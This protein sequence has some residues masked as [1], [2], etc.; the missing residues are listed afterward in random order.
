VDAKPHEFRFTSVVSHRAVLKRVERSDNGDVAGTDA[1]LAALQSNLASYEQEKQANQTNITNALLPAPKN[2]FEAARKERSGKKSNGPGVSQPTSPSL[3]AVGTSRLSSAPRS[4]PESAEDVKMQ[5]MKAP[6][7]HMLAMQPASTEDI[8]ERTHIPR[9]ELDNVLQK[10]GRQVDGKWQLTDRAYRELDIWKFEYPSAKERMTA[11]DNAVRAFDRMRI[12][13]E[14][15]LWQRLMSKEEREKGV[16]LSKLHFGGGQVNSLTPSYQPSPMPHA[17]AASDSRVAS[18]A[19]TPRLG[20]STTRPGSSKGD[21]MKRLLSKNPKKA[22]AAEEAKDRKRKER[23]AAA[24]D[25]EGPRPAKKQQTQKTSSNVKS[26]EFV[27]SSDDDS[28]DEPKTSPPSKAAQQT[29]KAKPKVQPTA[30]SSSSSDEPVKAKVAKKAAGGAK[31]GAADNKTTESP[32]L[33]ATKPM[34]TSKATP[35]TTNNLSAPN[36]QHKSSRSPQKQGSKPTVPSPLGAARPRVAS[37]VSDRGAVGVQRVRSNTNDS[38]RGLGITNGVKSQHVKTSG[39]E[40]NSRDKPPA[41]RFTLKSQKPLANGSATPKERLPNDTHSKVEGSL[42]RKAEH[43]IPETLKGASAVKH[44]KNNSTSSQSLNGHSNSSMSN[45]ETPRT[46]PDGLVESSSDSAG[47][48]IETIS[49]SQ[50]VA[51]A[52][53]FRDIYYPAYEKLY[54]ELQARIAKGEKVPEEDLQRLLAMHKRC[55]QFKKEMKAASQREHKD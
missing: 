3:G 38:P 17:D 4:V 24:S 49:Y 36:S 33:K 28:S 9:S 5:A 53:K 34:P 26:A 52:E 50:G 51:V 10:Y 14:D 31:S 25:R 30:A 27:H 21:V 40:S 47:S 1:A 2:R 37:D 46:S 43:Q 11:R 6:L 55:E 22:Q 41:D 7:L 39:A 45:Q 54:D 19:N 13:K 16:I 15:K 42:K 35:S 48:V 12:G 32:A 29:L 44:R 8:V 23:E 20:P 18:T